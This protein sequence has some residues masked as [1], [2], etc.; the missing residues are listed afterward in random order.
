MVVFAMEEVEDP[1]ILQTFLLLYPTFRR[2][3]RA[4]GELMEEPVK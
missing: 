1:L 2:M 3:D 4:I